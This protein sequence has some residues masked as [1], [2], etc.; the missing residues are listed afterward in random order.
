[1]TAVVIVDVEVMIV[2]GLL[3]VNDKRPVAA[4]WLMPRELIDDH[5]T[6]MVAQRVAE[7]VRL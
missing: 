1:M 4:G 7:G 6:V 5:Q 3:K 2:P